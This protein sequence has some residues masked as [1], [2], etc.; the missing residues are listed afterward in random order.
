M[1]IKVL[2]LGAITSIS[3]Y[4]QHENDLS[5]DSCYAKAERSYP[6]Y[7]Q[8]ELAER[9]KQTSIDASKKSYIPQLTFNAKASYQSEVI[10]IQEMLPEQLIAMIGSDNFTSIN[11]DQYQ[12]TL[13]LYQP[14]YDGGNLR[15]YKREAEAKAEVEKSNT[16]VSLYA[17]K[18]RIN[19]IYFGILLMDEQLRLNQLYA[20]QLDENYKNIVAY[21][22]NGVANDSDLD[23]V[24]VEQMKNKQRLHELNATRASLISNLSILINEP[25]AMACI[26]IP[27]QF[28]ETS[29]SENKRPELNYFKAQE[30]L[31]GSL[32]YRQQSAYIPR[33]GAFIQGG[34][35]NP[36]LNFLKPGFTPYYVAGVKLSWNIGGLYTLGDTKQKISI[37]KEQIAKQRE[38]FL[39]NNTMQLNQYT[40]DLNKLE[41]LILADDEII[42][43]RERIRKASEIKVENG[44]KSVAD[45]LQEMLLEQGARQEKALHQVQQWITQYNIKNCLNT[46]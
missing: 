3:L 39:L 13:D 18:E 37:Q 9:F 21:V 2:V 28:Q 14:I 6:L 34:Y 40:N 43:L 27:P 4:A 35:G 16:H 36:G 20:N 46:Y 42:S 22:A 23:L 12:F 41:E 32:I 15:A 8:L 10:N 45:L 33:I 38:T 5:L 29:S 19:Q 7:S 17:I 30:T 26:L 24:K 31:V 44:V 11:Q 1:R 25:I